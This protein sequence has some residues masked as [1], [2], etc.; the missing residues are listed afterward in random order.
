VLN[1]AGICKLTLNG[2][3]TTST[4]LMQEMAY[5]GIRGMRI[6]TVQSCDVRFFFLQKKG[7]KTIPV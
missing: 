4:I 2:V 5:C 7:F 1:T 3:F 6:C